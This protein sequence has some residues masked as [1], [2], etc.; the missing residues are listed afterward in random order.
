MERLLIVNADDF[1][2]SE[3]VNDGIARSHRDG[4]LTSASLMVLW[5]AAID[6]VRRAG[7]L[8]LGLHLDLGEWVFRNGE[9]VALYERVPLEDAAAVEAEAN[10]Q[11]DEFTRLT[12]KTP[13]HIDS[14]QHVHMNEP[15]RSIVKRL[16][17]E[18]SVPLRGC[19]PGIRH[20]GQ[21]YGQSGE[22]E[23]Y[24]DGISVDALTRLLTELQPGTTE[25]GCHPGEDAQ[26]DSQYR[27]E[28]FQEVQVLCDPQ[29]RE[30][31]AA[32]HIRLCTFADIAACDIG[33]G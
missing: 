12:G 15:V 33:A 21:F 4:I 27:Q 10:R 17:A 26:L 16:T 25:L 22:G 28:R 8:A 6:A 5:P 24:P 31:I 3:G 11:L 14:H 19:T 30:T 7:N 23:P 13:T 9:W 20:C 2:L 18:L 32:E 1:G 29:I